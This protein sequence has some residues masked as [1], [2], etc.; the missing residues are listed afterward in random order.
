MWTFPLRTRGQ[1]KAATSHEQDKSLWQQAWSQRSEKSLHSVL[2]ISNIFKY[3][4]GLQQL[5]YMK[6]IWVKK[7]EVAPRHIRA[8]QCT[9]VQI[10]R[11]KSDT[12]ETIESGFWLHFTHNV[13][14]S[15]FLM[16]WIFSYNKLHFRAVFWTTELKPNP[17]SEDHQGTITASSAS[18]FNRKKKHKCLTR[19]SRGTASYK[20]ICTC[21]QVCVLI[22]F[23]NKI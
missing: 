8:V 11:H 19:C 21:E 16:S 20:A 15:S 9:V 4:S 12:I 3:T 17:L 5:K 23:I 10:L 2:L 13:L 14:F 22:S 1:C 7:A 6:M 18:L